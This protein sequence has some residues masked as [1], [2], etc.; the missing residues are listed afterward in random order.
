LLF[1]F[2]FTD[3]FG[4]QIAEVVHGI[5]AMLFIALILGHIYIGTVGMEGAFDGMWTGEVDLNWATE[6]HRLWLEEDVA[7]AGDAGRTPRLSSTPAA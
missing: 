3:I 5:T 6:H 7:K 1:P 4:M 2:Y